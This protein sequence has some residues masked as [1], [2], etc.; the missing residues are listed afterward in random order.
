MDPLFKKLARIVV[1]KVIAIIIIFYAFFD[2]PSLPTDPVLKQ[3]QINSHFV[4]N[5]EK[6]ND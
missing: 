2:Q 1:I 4:N 6:N 5:S 3:Q